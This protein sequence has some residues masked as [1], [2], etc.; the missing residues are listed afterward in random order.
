MTFRDNW[1]DDELRLKLLNISASTEAIGAEVA[2]IAVLIDTEKPDWTTLRHGVS[3]AD[4]AR[5]QLELDNERAR[6]LQWQLE[7]KIRALAAELR[8]ARARASE[9]AQCADA[10]DRCIR[11]RFLVLGSAAKAA[12]REIRRAVARLSDVGLEPPEPRRDILS[13]QSL[14][15][16]SG[17]LD[18]DY[19]LAANPDVAAADVDPLVHYLEFGGREGRAPSAL[20]D[21]VRYLD[22]NPDLREVGINPLLHFIL[23]GVIERRPCGVPLDLLPYASPRGVKK[24]F[25]ENAS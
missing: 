16:A 14:V 21:G 12:R 22:A 6:A 23:Y 24:I 9:A 13:D 5:A 17:L 11:G 3:E 2:R 4:R 25:V 10:A 7:V 20:F 18:R 8:R 15:A 1:A 19:Y